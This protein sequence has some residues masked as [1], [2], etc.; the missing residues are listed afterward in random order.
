[1]QTVPSGPALTA[2]QASAIDNKIDDGLPTKGNVLAQY[3]GV[4]NSGANAGQIGWSTSG[5]TPSATTCYDTS[6]GTAAYSVGY[7]NGSNVTCGL[8]FKFQTGD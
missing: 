7:Q 3:L 2:A 4:S 5:S 6:S 1:M 8:S